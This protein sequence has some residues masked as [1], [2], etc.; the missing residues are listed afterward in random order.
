M[1][2]GRRAGPR[3]ARELGRRRSSDA[4]A[5]SRARAR[6]GAAPERRGARRLGFPARLFGHVSDAAVDFVTKLLDRDV[7]CRIQPLVWVVLTKLENSLAR[8]HRSRFG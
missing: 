5:R 6:A 4:A 8:S 3:D 2:L 7:L 1:D